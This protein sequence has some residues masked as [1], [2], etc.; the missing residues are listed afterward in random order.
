M[1]THSSRV[2]SRNANTPPH[3]KK[4]KS[5]EEVVVGLGIWSCYRADCACRVVVAI[6]SHFGGGGSYFENILK[7][8]VSQRKCRC[9]GRRKKEHWERVYI[10]RAGS[11]LTLLADVRGRRR[12]TRSHH[13]PSN[14]HPHCKIP[15]VIITHEVHSDLLFRLKCLFTITVNHINAN[16]M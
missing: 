12:T 14:P 15:A 11:K 8:G 7:N 9:W 10:Y 5:P 6:T 13:T 4:K 16:L 2:G 3:E 1:A